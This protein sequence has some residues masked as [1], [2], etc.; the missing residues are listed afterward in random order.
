[1]DKL[2]FRNSTRGSVKLATKRDNSHKWVDD[3]SKYNTLGLL[4]V[5][6]TSS[7]YIGKL[8]F[9]LLDLQLSCSC[10]KVPT[11]SAHLHHGLME[12]GTLYHNH[13]TVRVANTH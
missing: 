10:M 6:T 2:E 5:A 3:R 12:W 13:M 11:I 1:M 8:V 7:C 9:R 4:Y